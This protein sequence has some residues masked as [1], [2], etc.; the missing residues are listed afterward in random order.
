MTNDLLIN[1]ELTITVQGM[2]CANCIA[3]VEQGLSRVAG[4]TS[5]K[6]D[7]DAAGRRPSWE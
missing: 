3:K 2:S 6:V 7:L 1:G 4:V 5:V